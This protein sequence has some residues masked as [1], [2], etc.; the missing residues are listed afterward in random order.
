MITEV[1][2]LWLTDDKSTSVFQGLFFS[3]CQCMRGKNLKIQVNLLSPT[4]KTHT[5]IAYTLLDH[6]TLVKRGLGWG[7]GA[8]KLLVDDSCVS[9]QQHNKANPW[10][11]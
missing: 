2:D 6:H 7:Y 8:S 10:I 1:S 5:A 9:K 11:F 3:D 4:N